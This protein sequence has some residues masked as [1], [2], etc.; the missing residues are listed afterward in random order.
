[1]ELL[2]QGRPEIHFWWQT[3]IDSRYFTP[4]EPPKRDIA[5]QAIA[6][7]VKVRFPVSDTRRC[8]FEEG[9][10]IDNERT[11]TK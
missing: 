6:L 7:R 4:S 2:G 5:K 9:L 1:M 11:G 3:L 8:A 10:N